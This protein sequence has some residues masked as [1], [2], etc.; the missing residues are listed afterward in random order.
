[1]STAQSLMQFQ[2]E[3]RKC[4]EFYGGENLAFCVSYIIILKTVPC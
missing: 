2:D 3:N 1:M 4:L